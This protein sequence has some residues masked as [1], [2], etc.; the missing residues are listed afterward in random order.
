MILA[1]ASPFKLFS[2]GTVF[3]DLPSLYR[4]QIL[5]NKDGPR[6]ERIKICLMAVGLDL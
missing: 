5:T 4:L 2:A 6:Y 3:N 1:W